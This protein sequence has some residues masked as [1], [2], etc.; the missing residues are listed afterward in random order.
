MTRIS[1]WFGSLAL[2][3]A[4]LAALLWQAAPAAAFNHGDV[5]VFA[6]LPNGAT[7]PEGIA[8]SPGDEVYVATFGFNTAGPVAGPGKIYVYNKNGALLRTLTVAGTSSHLIGIGFHPTTNVLLVID[9]GSAN[10]RA[11]N[12]VTGASAIFMTLPAGMAAGAGLNAM[13]FDAAGNV[14][15]SDSFQGIIWQ[16]GAGGGEATAWVTN[17]LLTTT[18]TPPF[19]ANGLD[20]NAAQDALFV[21]NT[22][23]DTI[24]RIPVAAGV[25]GAP[26]VFVN[27]INGADGLVIDPDDNIW[28][29][30]NQ[31]DE[32]VVLDP[33]GK[34]IAKLGDFSG[35]TAG[36]VPNG[37][38]F[39]AT[40][41][42]SRNGRTLY[43][44][45]LALDIR[46]FGL[47]QSG[48]SQWTAQVN[49]YTV[50]RIRTN[51]RPLSGP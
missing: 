39:P 3:G 28:V 17:A 24:V 29:A 51:F 42:F 41:A 5:E 8:V 7:G 35:L 31:A 25:P 2:I 49:R 15:V 4:G 18:G 1:R 13:T 46:L 16:V 48:D 47:A 44:T 50:S 30:A 14:Y 12:R 22:G 38:L 10:V 40:P 27:S 19:G 45:N 21:A 9:N 43:V 37:L 23:N 32:I 34:T 11:V 20:F 33:T 26:A 6:V 36:G